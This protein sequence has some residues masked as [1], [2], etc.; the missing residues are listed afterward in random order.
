MP[1]VSKAVE[2]RFF[3]LSASETPSNVMSSRTMFEQRQHNNNVFDLEKLIASSNLELKRQTRLVS[4]FTD[5]SCV[6]LQTE[7]H[8]RWFRGTVCAAE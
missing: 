2:N 5:S 7:N 8:L 6:P 3:D 1:V 4:C